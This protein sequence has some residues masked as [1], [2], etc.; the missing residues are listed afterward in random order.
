VGSFSLGL[1]EECA[2]KCASAV[3]AGRRRRYQA[4]GCGD[5]RILVLLT[6]RGARAQS[7]LVD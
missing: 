1:G 5:G 6:E 7:C 3:G 2:K 4:M